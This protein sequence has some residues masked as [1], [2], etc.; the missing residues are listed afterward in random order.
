MQSA[1]PVHARRRGSSFG[2]SAACPRQWRS[3]RSRDD[4][5]M[6]ICPRWTVPR[7]LPYR[8]SWARSLLR[9]LG[10]HVVHRFALADVAK[11]LP[12]QLF[13]PARIVLEPVDVPPQA[14][15]GPL[16]L[17]NVLLKLPGMIPHGKIPRKTHLTK[18]ERQ[19]QQ[20]AHTG[21]HV[22][23]SGRPT[24]LPIQPFPPS[25]PLNEHTSFLPAHPRTPI[26]PS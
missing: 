26:R 25:I 11:P 17:S 24:P 12:G 9:S 4:S 8:T 18:E 20:Q 19:E 15:G 3:S 2:S 5:T 14:R 21:G 6:W 7:L 22:L 16:Q 23:A 13:D 10:N 1:P